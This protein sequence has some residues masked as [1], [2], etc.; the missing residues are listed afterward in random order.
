MLFWSVMSYAVVLALSSNLY[1]MFCRTP[2]MMAVANGHVDTVLYLI[3][4]G[5]IVNAKDSQGR[6]SLHRGVSNPS[7]HLNQIF[8]TDKLILKPWPINIGQDQSSSTL[9]DQMANSSLINNIIC[10]T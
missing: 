8:L 5:A 6:T 4:N 9:H 7:T 10:Q 1:A 3:A 2:L